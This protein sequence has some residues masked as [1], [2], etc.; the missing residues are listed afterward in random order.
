MLLDRI[1]LLEDGL[2]LAQAEISRLRDDATSMVLMDGKYPS[3][4]MYVRLPVPLAVMD[5]MRWLDPFFTALLKFPEYDWMPP[6]DLNTVVFQAFVRTA[7]ELRDNTQF[8]DFRMC[9]FLRA[10]WEL[11]AAQVWRSY[12]QAFGVAPVSVH[13]VNSS[14]QHPDTSSMNVYQHVAYPNATYLTTRFPVK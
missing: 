9:I 12:I 10:L 3:I 8:A 11:P 6:V 7:D 4:L 5:D 2:S 13:G 14:T 1:M